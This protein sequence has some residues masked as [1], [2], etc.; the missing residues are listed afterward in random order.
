[1]GLEWSGRMRPNGV[2]HIAMSVP[3]LDQARAFYV[4]LLGLE[5][6]W[7]MAWANSP[8]MDTI[9]ALTG[10]AGRMIFLDAGDLL[11]EVFEFQSP[12]PEQVRPPGTMHHFGFTHICF[13]V[14]DARAEHARLSAAGVKFLS[15][16]QDSS[17]VCTLYGMDPFGN[18]FELQ[19][20]KG[21]AKLPSK[22][23][24]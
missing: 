15:E 24:R 8:R 9:T 7:D 17:N 2:H 19:Q 16:P 23:G 3:D 21:E 14:A 11:L 13:D 5:E 12:P 1:M 10:S 22:V 4:G 18:V 20:I 6:V